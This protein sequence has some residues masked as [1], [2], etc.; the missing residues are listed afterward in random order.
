MDTLSNLEAE[1]R[2]LKELLTLE[3]LPKVSEICTR[4]QLFIYS[5][6]HPQLKLKEPLVVLLESDDE[7][8]IAFCHDLEVFG[9]GDTEGEALSDLRETIADLYFELSENCQKLGPFP[10][11]V[12]HYLSQIIE[13]F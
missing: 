7:Q 3:L 5:L 9:Y 12:L 11:K 8:T 1:I 13:K 10:Q 2:D 4:K 6:H